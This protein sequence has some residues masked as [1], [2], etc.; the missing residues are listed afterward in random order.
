MIANQIYILFDT[1]TGISAC[2]IV[3]SHDLAM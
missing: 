3:V 1:V 2:L